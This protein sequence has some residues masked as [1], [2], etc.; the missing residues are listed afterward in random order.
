MHKLSEFFKKNTRVHHRRLQNYFLKISIYTHLMLEIYSTIYKSTINQLLQTYSVTAP[1]QDH[2]IMHQ[3]SKDT[4]LF[5]L[6]AVGAVA[7]FLN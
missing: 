4:N 5:I 7:Q 2:L 3:N 1:S 6:N